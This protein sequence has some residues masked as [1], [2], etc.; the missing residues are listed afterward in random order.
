MVAVPQALPEPESYLKGGILDW[1]TT[2]D[3]KKIA[4]MYGIT[5][6]IFFLF[7]GLE[8]LMLRIQLMSPNNTLLGA[9]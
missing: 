1:L 5:G 3:H 9:D 7:G 4:V 6:L 8:A 2:T